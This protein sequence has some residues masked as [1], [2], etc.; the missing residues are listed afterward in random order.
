GRAGPPGDGDA[1]AGARRARRRPPAVPRSA[2]RSRAGRAHARRFP[3]CRA[4]AARLLAAEPRL[5]RIALPAPR[6]LRLSPARLPGAHAALLP[7]AARGR[8]RGLGLVPPGLPP[9]LRGRGGIP[10]PP[11]PLPRLGGGDARARRAV[12]PSLPLGR[13]AAPLPRRAGACGV[14]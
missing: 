6:A 9:S 2:H 5:R 3:G 14:G 4:R 8:A 10:P 13:A 12:L 1:R 11:R 7:R